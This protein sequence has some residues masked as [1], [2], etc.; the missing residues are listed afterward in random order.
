LGGV[1]LAAETGIPTP[2]SVDN[3]AAYLD[4]WLKAM[5]AD[6]RV[7]FQVVS[8]AS[9]G[10]DLVLSFSRQEQPEEELAA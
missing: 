4:H 9:Q 3:H 5:R 1:Y 2:E 7:I 10:A 6:S 8:A